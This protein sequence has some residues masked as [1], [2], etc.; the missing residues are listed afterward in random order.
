MREAGNLEERLIDVSLRTHGLVVVALLAVIGYGVY[1]YTE[2]PVD[3][4][5]DISPIMV[6]VFAE[7][8]G[9]APEEVERLITY[10]IETAMNG[11]PD[12]TQIKSTSAFGMAVIYV[13]F[14]DDTDIYFAR[15][16][17]A[18]RLA[19]A[20]ND[21][22]EMHDPPALGPISTGLG[23]IFI[24]YLTADETVD[25][26]GKDANT[27]LREL[28]DWVVKR[29]LQSV[30]G[31]T[32]VLSVGGHVLQY[33]IRVRP[34]A[35]RKYDV[36]LADIVEAVRSNNRNVGG[37]FLV[38]GSEE[39]LVR[40][41]GL[42]QTLDDIRRVPLKVVSGTP[43][44]ISDVADVEYGKEIRRGVV[45]F[46]GE[47]TH[48]GATHEVHKEVVSGMVLKLYGENTS[49]VIDRLYAKVEQVRKSLPAGVTLVPYYE[50][51][52][53]VEQATG[54]VKKALLI[55]AALVM[56]TLAVFLGN[57]RTAFIVALSLPIS[58]LVA[59]IVMGW[60][61]V[62]ANLMSL[63]G[64]AI[65]IGMLGD[66]AIV[67]VE[68]I[69]RHL[70]L[71][72][73]GKSKSEIIHAA[74]SEVA[75]PIVFSIAI[76]VLVFVPIFSFE[77]VEGKM[78]R[79]LAFTI[80]SAL[81]GSMA[82]AL[83]AA[84]VLSMYLLKQKVHRELFLVRWLK[85][86]YRPM[87]VGA[88]R[89][90]IAVA[91]VALGA[92][93]AS[94]LSLRYIGTEFVPTLEEGSVMIGVALAPSISLEEATDTIIELEKRLKQYGEVEEVI[95]RI[96]RPEAGSH[97]HPVNYAEVHIELKPPD[98]WPTYRTKA[99]LVKALDKDLSRYPGINLSFT[100]PIQNAFDELLSG[101]KAQLA[102]KV[103]GEDL[104]VLQNLANEIKEAIDPKDANGKIKEGKGVRGLTDLSVEQSFGQPQVQVIADR[105]AC[106]RHGVP[107]SDIL[108]IVELAVGGE[109]IDSLYLN[110]RRFG[111]HVRYDKDHRADGEAIRNIQVNT[112]GGARIP[113]SMVAEV[114][115]VVGPIQINREKNQR[116]WVVQ[117]N[118]RGRDLGS[119]VGDVK[120]VIAEKV[121]WPKGYEPPEF[122]G[123][124]AN[125]QR[126]MKRLGI[127]VPVVIAGVFLM[128]WGTFGSHRHAM[129]VI[130]GVPLSLI[131]GIAGLLIT[132]EYLSVPASVGFIALF[133]IAV[134]N[135]LVLVSTIKQL[136]SEGMGLNDALIEGGLLRLRPV[137]MTAITTILGL[138]PLLL[139]P[140]IGSEVQ[141]PLAVVVVFGLASSTVLTLFV[142]PAVYGWF[143]GR[144]SDSGLETEVDKNEALE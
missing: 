119:V 121:E 26:E 140:G 135:G 139:L 79:P 13:Y 106:S 78:F 47:E 69:Y 36:S 42:L 22:P 62:S 61:N 50:Q 28:N 58:A 100:Q 41:L 111:I 123:Q 20:M 64:I 127:I 141:R 37:Q 104:D 80:T 82:M 31:V 77:G 99:E 74:A 120:K 84:P 5:P 115:H 143:E 108:E 49:E 125:Q 33:Q 45:S 30:P 109:A 94:M 35:L 15:Q 92:F 52:E 116:R 89:A 44:Y 136:R 51:A 67:M 134:Q 107:V 63:G 124:F 11:L 90:R 39:H 113:L 73:Q 3:A 55:G 65:A 81:L 133:G 126:A 53:L 137:L 71:P 16:L 14:E 85:A 57:V 7:A 70:S 54:T 12:V 112:S 76:I 21:L 72:S 117:A 83:I 23:Q 1:A 17:V 130:V 144:G 43:V 66:G 68:N 129:M 128:L 34:H 8:H 131:G 132:G 88:I 29:Q 75:R 19:A 24:Y 2:M 98:Q 93:T 86:V 101:T 103:Y 96:G 142:I 4:F 138:L 25:T 97:P 114:K 102:I 95:S 110:T 38:L 60:Q 6:P 56:L 9:M 27:Y 105:E 91:I 59:V 32:D 18:E 118:I 46:C 122:G 10:P 87:L 40:G 48:D